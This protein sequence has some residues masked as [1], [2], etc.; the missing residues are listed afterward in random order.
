MCAKPAI[1]PFTLQKHYL[2]GSDITWVSWESSNGWLRYVCP[3]LPPLR[4]CGDEEPHRLLP[5][6]THRRCPFPR[7]GLPGSPEAMASMAWR[8]LVWIGTVP[9]EGAIYEKVSW[10]FPAIWWH[11]EY[12]MCDITNLAA[13]KEMLDL[14]I[15]MW[16]H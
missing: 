7:P 15:M 12:Q 8:S 14:F 16:I 9:E 4:V 2:D 5:R 13:K 6:P 11:Y 10:Y 1:M 3:V